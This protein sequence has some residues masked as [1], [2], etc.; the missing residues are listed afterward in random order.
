M[1]P[2]TA[3]DKRELATATE[4][5]GAA[6]SLEEGGQ[7]DVLHNGA[8]PEQPIPLP[9]TLPCIQNGK[10]GW[11]VNTSGAQNVLSSQ[12]YTGIYVEVGC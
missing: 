11:E 3:V 6:A 12:W 1:P 9:E 2:L 7:D 8:I 10:G 5:A 4:E